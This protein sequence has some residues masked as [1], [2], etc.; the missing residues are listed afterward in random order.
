MRSA[1]PSSEPGLHIKLT[2]GITAT[3][4][5]VFR[6]RLQSAYNKHKNVSIPRGEPGSA[7]IG[8]TN[9][10]TKHPSPS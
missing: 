10:R 3:Q 9:R 1:H 7:P 8:I 2:D 5:K 6:P 4:A